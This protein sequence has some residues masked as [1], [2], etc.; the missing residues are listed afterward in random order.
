MAKACLVEQ[1]LRT[2]RADGAPVAA[3]TGA[4]AALGV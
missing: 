2:H 4:W 3:P 1:R